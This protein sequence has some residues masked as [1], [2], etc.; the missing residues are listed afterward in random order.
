MLFQSNKKV[1]SGGDRSQMSE[2]LKPL[3]APSQKDSMPETLFYDTFK[4]FL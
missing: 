1:D 2:W 4:V 3:K